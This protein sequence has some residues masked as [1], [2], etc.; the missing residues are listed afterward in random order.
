MRLL[1]L[2]GAAAFLA[3]AFQAQRR[4]P[5]DGTAWDVSVKRNFLLALPRKDTLVFEGGRLSVAG[6][7]SKGFGPGSYSVEPSMKGE[8]S[9]SASLGDAAGAVVEWR[10]RVDGERISGTAL[11]RDP[12]GGVRR[13]AFKGGRRRA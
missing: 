3:F 6:C 5:I 1:L 11:W 4:A 12:S 10:G 2:A 13:Y 7:V 9:W 8:L